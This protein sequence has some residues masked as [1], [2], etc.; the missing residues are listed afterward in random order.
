MRGG[1]GLLALVL[2]IAGCAAGEGE[3][4][5][6]VSDHR[7]ENGVALRVIWWPDR[8]EVAYG[9]ERWVLPRAISASGARYTDET[10]EIWDH[11][12]TIRVTTGGRAPVACRPEGR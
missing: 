9:S 10:H 5:V 1:F 2:M 11:Q 8:A 3:K 7:C 6:A 12:G 4:P